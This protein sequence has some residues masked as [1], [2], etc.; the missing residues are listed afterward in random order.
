VQSPPCRKGLAI[1]RTKT[2]VSTWHTRIFLTDLSTAK[3]G[4]RLGVTGIANVS[5]NLVSWN[6]GLH[7]NIAQVLAT[8][9]SALIA[10]L[11]SFHWYASSDQILSHIP[12]NSIFF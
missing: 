3:Y 1:R 5:S 7:F 4:E 10:L 2:G 11:S 12:L 8:H 9:W 6:P